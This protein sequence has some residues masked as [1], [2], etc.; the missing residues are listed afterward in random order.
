MT[1]YL[2]INDESIILKYNN[3]AYAKLFCLILQT[4]Y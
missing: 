1:Q 2:F 3:Y 4:F